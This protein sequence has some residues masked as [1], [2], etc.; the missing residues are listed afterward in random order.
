LRIFFFLYILLVLKS[1]DICTCI[2]YKHALVLIF[3]FTLPNMCGFLL[4]FFATLHF[5]VYK[6]SVLFSFFCNFFLFQCDACFSSMLCIFCV[7]LFVVID[8]RLQMRLRLIGQI[9]SLTFDMTF[10]FCLFSSE[11]CFCLFC[12]MVIISLFSLFVFDLAKN[13]VFRFKDMDCRQR[14]YFLN[15]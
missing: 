14:M 9:L 2:N 11:K 4:L 8:L 13:Y 6:P 12:S 15:F 10:L 3:I 5:I 7:N 1:Y